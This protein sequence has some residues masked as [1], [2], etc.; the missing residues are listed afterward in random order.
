MKVTDKIMFAREYS[1][2]PGGA[3]KSYSIHNAS[4]DDFVNNLHEQGIDI[5]PNSS[6]KKVKYCLNGM[7]VSHDW[8]ESIVPLSTKFLGGIEVITFYLR[9]RGLELA[10]SDYDSCEGQ[11]R[12]ARGEVRGN[13][14]IVGELSIEG[15]NV[16]TAIVKR[17]GKIMEE[18]YA[19]Q[20][21]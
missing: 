19:P 6:E 11:G 4:I 2:P 18:T 9:G 12:G 3:P 7:G 8:K 17:I 10:L 20:R 21:G 5:N 16:D 14:G 15:T 1:G 13:I